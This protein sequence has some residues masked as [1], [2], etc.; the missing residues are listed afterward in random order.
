MSQHQPMQ[1][2]VEHERKILDRLREVF[3]KHTPLP[4]GEK[5]HLTID[6]FYRLYRHIKAEGYGQ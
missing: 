4:A 3:L 5:E 2:D 1:C 6:D